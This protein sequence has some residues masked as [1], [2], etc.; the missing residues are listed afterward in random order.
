V[1]T[2]IQI[3]VYNDKII[4]WNEGQLPENLTL[5]SLLE[6]HTSRPYNPV[7]ANALF[8]SGYSETW[9]RGT[10]K[11]IKECKQAGIP[12][13]VFSFD[14]SDISV[15]FRNNNNGLQGQT[16]EHQLPTSVPP[17]SGTSNVK[18]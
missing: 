7:I 14:S 6:K 15:E 3:S 4:F 13:P 10:L 1:I 18:Q 11:T 12:E 17:A 8:C 2:T 9:G 16:S 5:K